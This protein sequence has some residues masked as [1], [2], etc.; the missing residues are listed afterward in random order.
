MERSSQLSRDNL[1]GNLFNA[2]FRA[3]PSIFQPG[4]DGRFLDSSRQS[5]SIVLDRKPS[6]CRY[7]ILV[8]RQDRDVYC[9]TSNQ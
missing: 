3:S 5:H 8:H 2:C 7:G 4:M 6:I 1:S 9:A